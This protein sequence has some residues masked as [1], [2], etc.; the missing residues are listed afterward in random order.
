M[1]FF[2]IK[3]WQIISVIFCFILGTSLHFVYELSGENN[4]IAIFSSVN[5]STW[6]HL[7]LVFFPMLIT[8]IIGFFVVEKKNNNYWFAQMIGII[9]SMRIY[10]S[11]FLYIYRDYWAKL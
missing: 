11:I 6:E 9:C 5:E 1:V 8:A 3:T 2:K 4:I 10:N 7:K